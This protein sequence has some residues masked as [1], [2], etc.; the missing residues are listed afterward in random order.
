MGWRGGGEEELGGSDGHGVGG[1][2]ELDG[3]VGGAEEE[4]S[5]GWRKE[6]TILNCEKTQEGTEEREPLK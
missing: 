4:L 5:G 2:E 6:H 3:K 1:A